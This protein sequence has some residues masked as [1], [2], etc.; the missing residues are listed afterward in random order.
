METGE[1]LGRFRVVNKIGEGGM[2]EV[3]L[4]DDPKLNRQIALKVLTADFAANAERMAR[5][6]YE[7]KSASALNHPN[8]ITIHEIND[9]HDTPFI[10]MEHVEG[11]TLGRKMKNRPLEIRESIDIAIQ[12]AAALAAAHEAKIIHRDIKPDNVIVRPDGLVKVLDF[13]LAK[14]IESASTAG[15]DGSTVPDMLTHPGFVIGTIAYMSPEQ[16]RGQKVDARSDIFSFGSMLY[17]MVSGRLPFAGE[18]NIDIIASILHKEPRSLSQSAR[19]IPHDMDALIRK[20]LRKNRDERYQTMRELQ[21]DLRELRQ[22][23]DS[24]SL[25]VNGNGY[26][27]L[28]LSD[29]DRGLPTEPM[30]LYGVDATNPISVAPSTF[31]GILMTEF[32]EH[33]WKSFA[34]SAFAVII[35]AGAAFGLYRLNGWSKKA[36]TF[37]T[38][39]FTQLTYSGTVAA[40]QAAVSPDGKYIAYVTQEPGNQSLWVKQ[41]AA[42]SNVQIVPPSPHKFTG[43]AFTPDA[44]HV[45]YTVIEKEG[46]SSLYQVPT[47][48]GPARKLVTDAKGTVAFSPDGKQMAFVRR[49]RSLML[50]NLD[51]SDTRVLT[52]GKDRAEWLRFSW[53]PDGKVIAASYYSPVD[54]MDHLIEISLS[55][56]SERPI[57][58]DQ[59]YRLRGIVWLK[60]GSGLLVSGRDLTTLNSQIWTIDY[61]S[62]NR[63]RIT[64]DLNN[65]QGLSLTADGMNI[66]STQPNI[67]SDVWIGGLEGLEKVHKVTSDSGKGNGISGVALTPDGRI[68]Y[69]TGI[70]ER[71]DIWIANQDG[72]GS[73]QLTFNSQS[74]F[75]PTVSPKGDSIVFVSTRLGNPDIWKMDSDGSSQVPLVSSS[76][77]EADPSFSTDG[78][79]IIFQSTDSSNETTIWKVGIDGGKAVQITKT[80]T[81]KPAISP[82]NKYI[83]CT[84]G[85]ASANSIMKLGI[86][87]LEDGELIRVLDETSIAK[88]RVIRWSPDGKSVIYIDGKNQV[89]NLWSQP[90]NKSEAKQLTGFGSDRIFRFDIS[91]ID[92]R[93]AVSRGNDTSDVVMI[94]N[95]R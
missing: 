92:G 79:W 24:G 91:P 14:Q 9:E 95:F 1:W 10:T 42:E 17:Q 63:R 66:V 47:L 35:I 87:S 84:F 77:R 33:P 30:N 86:V 64:N 25:S 38:M 52:T 48:G 37:Q 58:S 40:E 81:R 29:F 15:F 28:S 12:V 2:G 22:Q 27:P 62:G 83:A 73:R 60:D 39:R 19:L 45:Y 90:L 49:E 21:A 67:V 11:E 51:G 3:Y 93:V 44:N 53:S 41:T 56:G 70:N 75:S 71:Q 76:A 68:A 26:E 61:P 8:I 4:A 6:V 31:S 85:T 59:W 46:L 50:A 55:D 16:A 23:M 5:F 65:Y 94:S 82:D 54:D 7:A 43:V 88:S 20:S 78:N 18:N 72:S 74:N 34:I 36:E 89:D 57:S 13:G 32:R 69:T 80:D